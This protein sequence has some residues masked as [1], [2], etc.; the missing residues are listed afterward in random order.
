MPT[1]CISALI[2]K[3][4]TVTQ[5]KVTKGSKDVGQSK[6]EKEKTTDLL[7]QYPKSRIGQGSSATILSG[8]LPTE[9]GLNKIQNLITW[10]PIRPLDP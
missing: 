7:S 3:S 8:S 2:K 10:K 6:S 1:H 4:D 5:D 9:G